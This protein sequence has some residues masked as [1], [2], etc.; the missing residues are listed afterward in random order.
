MKNLPQG[1][2]W[3]CW[4]RRYIRREVKEK[5]RR[6]YLKDDVGVA[7]KEEVENVEGRYMKTL[8]QER[9]CCCG[10]GRNLRW[11]FGEEKQNLPRVW[12][13]S[14]GRGRI[15]W[16]PVWKDVKTLLQ[17][18]YC[19]CGHG[20]SVMWKL[21]EE[22]KNLPRGWCCRCEYGRSWGQWRLV[23]TTP[24]RSL[25]WTRAMAHP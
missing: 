10:H 5:I 24:P 3:L 4:R 6:T 11:K 12:R 1:R 23:C 9:C 15:W 8:L 7:G 16:C 25:G 20:R 2:R 13:C 14:C 22:N 19:C 18:R 21:G 17:E